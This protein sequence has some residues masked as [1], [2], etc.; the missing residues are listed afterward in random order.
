MLSATKLRKE[1]APNKSHLYESSQVKSNK[2][3]FPVLP[4]QCHTEAAVV[5][6][7]QNALQE[8]KLVTDRNVL[9]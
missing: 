2:T 1:A 5:L 3:S 8:L 7:P 6:Q 4:F 9:F